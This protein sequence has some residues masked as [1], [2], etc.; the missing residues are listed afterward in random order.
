MKEDVYAR[1][2]FSRRVF[3]VWCNVLDLAKG[4]IDYGFHPPT[5]YFPHNVPEA[6]MIEPTETE[7]RDVAIILL[8]KVSLLIEQARKID[9]HDFQNNTSKSIG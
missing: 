1:I 9:L 8:E 6:I 4:L 3:K 2:C 7:D 5:I